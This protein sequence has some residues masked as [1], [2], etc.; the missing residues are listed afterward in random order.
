LRNSYKRFAAFLMPMVMGLLLNVPSV[1]ALSAPIHISGTAGEGVFL[2]P[3]P[4]TANPAIGWMPE[5]ASPDYNCFIWGQNIGGVPIWF[6]VN[7]NGV[8]GYYASYYDDSSYQSNEELTAKYG[9]QLCGSSTSAPVAQPTSAPS[10]PPAA[11]SPAAPAAVYFN[12]YSRD[13]P[14]GPHEVKD[15]ATID[16]PRGGRSDWYGGCDPSRRPYDVATGAAKDRPIVTLGGWSGGRLGLLS[17]LA[18][19]TVAQLKQLNYVLLIDPG[20]YWEDRLHKHREMVCDAHYGGDPYVR[21]LHVNPTAHWVVIAGL[22]TQSEDSKG[23]QETYFNDVREGP[24]PQVSS[25]ILICNY[26]VDHQTAFWSS[27]FW[28]QHQI[29]STR[30]ACPQLSVNGKGI[31]ASAGWHPI[32]N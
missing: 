2:R 24:Y 27:K 22:P 29:A 7:Y 32:N 4:S 23:I 28:I 20:P 31:K 3:D 1:C 5:G 8:T 9:V 16:L 15:G 6:N 19:A 21:W 18:N 30:N 17:F 13:D 26:P 12:P 10:A 11:G 25:R 14:E